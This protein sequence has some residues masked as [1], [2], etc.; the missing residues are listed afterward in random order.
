MNDMIGLIYKACYFLLKFYFYT[1]LLF[2]SKQQ[3]RVC[4]WYDASCCLLQSESSKNKMPFT[5]IHFLKHS[6]LRR[7]RGY[8]NAK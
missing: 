5:H 6:L 3:V 8:R 2:F 1:S 4:T 7:M